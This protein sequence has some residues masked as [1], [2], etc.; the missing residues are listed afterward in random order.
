MQSV[1][2]SSGELDAPTQSPRD[3][4][5][6][7]WTGR[8]LTGLIVVFLLVDSVGK[9]IPL[10]PYVEGTKK[11]GFPVESV[12]PLGAVLGAATTLHAVPRTQFVG[13][14]L[15]TAY[16]GGAT[17][18]HVLTGTAFWFPVLMGALLWAAYGLRSPS[19]RSLFLS[20]N[21]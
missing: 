6:M 2:V 4:R 1:S 8:V 20:K 10:A 13:A 12:R 7:V 9:L 14:L 3:S 15:L 11:F 17:A 21:R 18:A 16:L 19:L 5:A